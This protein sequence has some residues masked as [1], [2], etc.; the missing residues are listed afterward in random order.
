[1]GEMRLVHS[2]SMF[3]YLFTSFYKRW[4]RISSMNT[5]RN[6][7]SHYSAN[8]DMQRSANGSMGKAQSARF[9]W[10]Q[11]ASIFEF[12]MNNVRMHGKWDEKR[13]WKRATKLIILALTK[14]NRLVWHEKFNKILEQGTRSFFPGSI[15]ATSSLVLDTPSTKR[16]GDVAPN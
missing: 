13:E 5:G 4:T 7:G 15:K 16:C 6:W 1:M 8:F 10:Q 14:L 12:A 3:I 2:L 11:R 9:L